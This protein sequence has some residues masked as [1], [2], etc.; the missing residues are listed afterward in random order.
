MKSKKFVEILF[1]GVLFI[2]STDLYAQTQSNFEWQVVVPW[3]LA[4]AALIF[5]IYQYARRIKDI[6][7]KKIAELE[8]QKEFKEKE[9][10][11]TAK[12]AEA[13]YRA[14]LKEE[15]DHIDLLGSPEI[16]SKAVKLEDAFVS[17]CISESWRSEDRFN[18]QTKMEHLEMERYLTPEQVMNRAFKKNRLLLVIGDPGSGKTTLLKYYA[19]SCLNKKYSEFGFKEDVF[20]LY[21]PLRELEFNKENNEPVILPQNLAK[22]SERHLLNIPADRFHDWLHKRKTLVL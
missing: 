2:F 11:S 22:W 1:I 13:T 8:A 17:L 10:T 15:L 20:P 4:A 3:V 19:V 18:R 7:P 9:Q 5:A 6:K 14:A 16:E 21:F 12:T